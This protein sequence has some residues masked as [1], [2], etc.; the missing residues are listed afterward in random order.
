MTEQIKVEGDTLT[1]NGVNYQKV[2]EPEPQTFRGNIEY[3]LDVNELEWD[4]LDPSALSQ[5]VTEIIVDWLPTKTEYEVRSDDYM[6]GWNDYENELLKI[7]F[8]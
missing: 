1:Y 4:L 7:I 2:E 8:K 3:V 6:R 5:E